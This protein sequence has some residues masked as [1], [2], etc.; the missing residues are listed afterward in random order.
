MY[1]INK[2]TK[3]KFKIKKYCINY[4]VFYNIPKKGCILYIDKMSLCNQ[5]YNKNISFNSIF[6]I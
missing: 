4:N 2:K 3:K 6:I 5:S 1:K